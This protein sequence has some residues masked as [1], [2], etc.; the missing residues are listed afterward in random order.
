[1]AAGEHDTHDDASGA[2]A[3]APASRGPAHSSHPAI[4]PG[5]LAAG[6][7]MLA[8]LAALGL[9]TVALLNAPQHGRSGGPTLKP[10][11]VSTALPLSA[12][13]ILALLDRGPDFGPLADPQRRASCLTG[14]GYPASTRILGAR[15]VELGGHPGV[16]L[17]LP[18]EQPDTVVAL[19]V[20]P[21]CSSAQTGLLGDTVVPRQ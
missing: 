19:A 3:G 7:G 13:E 12:A 18:G 4:R 1:M 16:L 17:V 20:A 21:S 2:R 5:R 6:A 8:A 9:G 11:T 15:L 14:L 10:I